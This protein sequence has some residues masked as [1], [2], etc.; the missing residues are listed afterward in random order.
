MRF[1]KNLWKVN[2]LVSIFISLGLIP[3]SFTSFILGMI[4]SVCIRKKSKPL[5]RKV[6]CISNW[7][8]TF[9]VYSDLYIL[10]LNL[11]TQF[12]LWT[13]KISSFSLT[14]Q[15]PND[16]TG[17][18]NRV[19]CLIFAKRHIIF[20]WMNGKLGGFQKLK[21]FL[22]TLTKDELKKEKKADTWIRSHKLSVIADNVT[23]KII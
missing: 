4:V 5:I 8:F 3:G 6:C 18:T 21:I 20:I 15:K 23:C 16:P 19:V 1:M 11:L 13:H 22:L 10:T 14:I 17:K 7:N 12:R 2:L 9:S